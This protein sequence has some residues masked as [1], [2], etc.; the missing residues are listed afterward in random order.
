MPAPT[1]PTTT[2]DVIKTFA[3][4]GLSGAIL[5]FFIWKIAPLLNQWNKSLTEIYA[6]LA[7]IQKTLDGNIKDLLQNQK[8]LA[9]KL[10]D[11]LNNKVGKGGG[12]Q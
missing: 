2:L 4:F 11:I 8:E 1:E 6:S 7:V 12:G 9:G 5:A 10:L 3:D